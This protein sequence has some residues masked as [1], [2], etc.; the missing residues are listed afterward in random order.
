MSL[1]TTL[2]RQDAPA[3]ADPD[4]PFR[5]SDPP[6]RS[7]Y[8]VMEAHE[9]F[10]TRLG[11]FDTENEAIRTLRKEHKR[12]PKFRHYVVRVERKVIATIG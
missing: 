6:A 9:S 2:V 12:N 3:T 10:A 4:K 7:K 5:R 8:Q 11:E 1:I